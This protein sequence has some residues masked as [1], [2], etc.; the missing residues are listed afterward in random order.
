MHIVQYSE[1]GAIPS[2]LSK[3]DLKAMQN[4][5]ISMSDVNRLMKDEHHAKFRRKVWERSGYHR[6]S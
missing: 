2:M 3:S 6:T 4:G 1:D 5:K